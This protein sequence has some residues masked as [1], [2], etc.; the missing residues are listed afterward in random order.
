MC[1]T[2]QGRR[3]INASQYS[4]NKLKIESNQVVILVGHYW[5]ADSPVECIE[6]LLTSKRGHCRL[7]PKQLFVKIDVI[8]YSTKA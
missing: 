4:E 1:I 3:M 8:S 2:N 6:S 7:I 5:R